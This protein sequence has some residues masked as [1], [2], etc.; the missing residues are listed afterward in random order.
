MKGLIYG[1]D[2]NTR[3]ILM[4]GTSNLLETSLSKLF[5]SLQRKELNGYKFDLTQKL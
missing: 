3:E 4:Q 2:E 5:D 1:G